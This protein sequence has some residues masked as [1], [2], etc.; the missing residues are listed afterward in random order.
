M[1]KVC[2]TM[3]R[4]SEQATDFDVVLVGGGLAS[5]LCCLALLERRPGLRLA[6]VEREPR[7]GGNHTWC[8]H[9]A[10]VPSSA[11]SLMAPLVVQR[12]DGYTVRFPRR[13]RRLASPYA[14]ITSERLHQ[15]ASARIEAAPGCELLLGHGARAL[16]AQRVVLDD[17]RELHAKLVIDARGPTL[18]ASGSLGAQRG[19]Q[20]F[21]GLEL[22]VAP[23]TLTEPVLFDACIPQRDG[24]RF[25]YV[26]PL[27]SERVLVEET[28][29]SE[30][31]GLDEARCRS[32]ILDYAKAQGLSVRAVVRSERGVLPMPWK[33]AAFDL[34]ARPLPAG[35]RAGLFHPVTGY[36]L[37]LAIRFALALAESDLEDLGRSK[38][39]DFARAHAAQRPFLHLLTRLLFT[40]FAPDQRFSVLEHFYRLPE[41]VI[42]RFY[43][44][45]LTALDRARVFLG[46]PPRGFSVG[47]ALAFQAGVAT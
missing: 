31:P 12:W 33:D 24:F 29:F 11:R 46:A 37:P 35:Y 4:P 2:L 47:R 1:S 28:F 23:H 25:M 19:Y 8:F 26:L 16:H 7:L 45:Q 39:A 27:S 5:V 17:G 14:C 40:C 15:V 22:A 32:T 43:A 36:S 42:E 13:Q 38:L 44:A 3:S 34:A 41:S 21:V 20:K 9:A 30:Q 6:L 10:D 18:E